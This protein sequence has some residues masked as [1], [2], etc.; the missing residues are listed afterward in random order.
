LTPGK[1]RHRAPMVGEHTDEVLR[2]LGY[3]I[4]EIAEFR[5]AEIV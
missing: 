5:K 2:E 1:I 3:S 4:E